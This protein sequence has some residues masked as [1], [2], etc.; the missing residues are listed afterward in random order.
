MSKSLICILFMGPFWV[1]SQVVESNRV[2]ISVSIPEIAMIDLA[3]STS[4]IELSLRPPRQAGDP[5]DMSQTNNDS[6]WMNYTSSIAPKGPKKNISAQILSGSLPRGL[7]L[8]LRAGKYSGS[9]KGKQGNPRKDIILSNLP[10]VIV[11]NIGGAYS[12]KGVQQG[13]QLFFSLGYKKYENIDFGVSTIVIAFTL[14]D[15]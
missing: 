8:S 9:G 13:H 14:T 4:T 7:H 2:N 6:K 15:N 5:I 10:Q 3:P 12:G 11:K 1:Q